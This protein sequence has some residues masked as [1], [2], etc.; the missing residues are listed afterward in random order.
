MLL[1]GVTY[2]P[3]IADQR[4]SPAV[5]LA[6]Q[7]ADKGANVVYHDPHVQEWRALGN[8]A[9]PADDLQ[10]AVEGADLVILVQN[11]R[12][13]DVDALAAASQR[14]FDTRGVATESEKVAGC[15]GRLAGSRPTPGAQSRGRSLPRQGQPPG[16]VGLPA[17]VPDV[18]GRSL[19]TP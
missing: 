13:Y 18:C 17:A 15:D 9:T 6:R 14:F 12:D 1:L 2:K 3:N 10:A 19:A 11:H 4:E 7:L 5:P 16:R 8:R